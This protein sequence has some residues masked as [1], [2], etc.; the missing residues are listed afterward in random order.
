[1]ARET[2]NGTLGL[3]AMHGTAELELTLASIE[4]IYEFP[5]PWQHQSKQP[6]RCRVAG[7]R[8]GKLIG[9]LHKAILWHA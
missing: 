8:G 5:E 9:A 4:T 6:L 7:E 3:Q 1:M 2:T